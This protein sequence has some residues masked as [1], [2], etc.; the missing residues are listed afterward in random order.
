[1]ALVEAVSKTDTA[2][3]KNYAIIEDCKLE[4]CLLRIIYN[5]Q[6]FASLMLYIIAPTDLCEMV[7]R[8]VKCVNEK[9]PTLL[10]DMVRHD[11]NNNYNVWSKLH[12]KKSD[13]QLKNST[14]C[15]LTAWLPPVLHQSAAVWT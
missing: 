15:L 11:D 9:D 5:A 6:L 13:N 2:L 1:M 10:Q 14:P 7:A 3:E 8:S 12:Y 4:E